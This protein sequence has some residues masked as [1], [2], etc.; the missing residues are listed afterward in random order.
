MFIKREIFDYLDYV[1]SRSNGDIEKQ[2]P[3]HVLTKKCSEN[4]QQIYRGKPMPK[5]DFNKITLQLY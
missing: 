4:T 5:C 2:P 1:L 3:K